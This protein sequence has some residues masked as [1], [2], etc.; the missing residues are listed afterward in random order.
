MASRVYYSPFIPTFSG[1]GLPVA[2]GRLYFFYTGTTDLAPIYADA[3]MTTPLANPVVSDGAA[4]YPNIYLNEAITYR[5]RET[6]KDGTPLADDIDP[7]VPGAAVFV[8][9]ELPEF[10][11]PG[12]SALVGYKRAEAN[13]VNQTVQEHLRQILL[14][15]DFGDDFDALVAANVA[16][17]AQ[18]GTIFIPSG[19]AASF[20]ANFTIS[21]PN[22][23]LVFLGDCL[24][25]T[26]TFRIII[27]R[28]AH[29]SALR[30][31]SNSGNRFGEVEPPFTE[32]TAYGVRIDYKGT[33]GSGG[34]GA[35]VIG[36]N[37]GTV[38]GIVLEGLCIRTDEAGQ[39][40]W[41]II[42]YQTTF[43]RFD[44]IT[45]SNA[46][47]GAAG[48]DQG[49]ILL[50]GSGGG[51]AYCG[52]V[53]ILQPRISG[54]KYGIRTMGQVNGG[55]MIGGTL[56]STAVGSGTTYGLLRG[57]SGTGF[58]VRNTEIGSWD[59]CIRYE[60]TT[61]EDDVLARTETDA[62]GVANDV[63]LA[64]GV[65]RHRTQIIGGCDTGG[66]LRYF[67]GNEPDTTNSTL[68]AGDAG[69]NSVV[70]PENGGLFGIDGVG[71]RVQLVSGTQGA[72]VADPAGGA[73]VDGESR[74]AIAAII[75]RLQEHGL[76]G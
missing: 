18:G 48:W 14:V 40:A 47:A 30:Y 73:T 37:T 8:V 54:G 33:G 32:V 10:A 15:T 63:I 17:P 61:A 55:T 36:D 1:N 41:G 43:P 13:A 39:Y 4:R 75:D 59:E 26:N 27:A 56:N 20:T 49:G 44:R 64:V 76:I 19:F 71:T 45:I 38:E 23:V 67:D 9:P 28:T 51:D 22:T 21:K 53:E 58:V 6:N 52:Y 57:G 7:Y 60:G 2:N 34:H 25:E 74:V 62:P 31:W 5:V 29:N 50:D 69:G 12:G 72:T 65:E 35:I 46:G 42:G 66:G 11:D 68:L 3:G 16:L 70:I 24:L